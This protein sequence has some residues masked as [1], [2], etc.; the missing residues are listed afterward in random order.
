MKIFHLAGGGDNP[1]TYP[2][3]RSFVLGIEMEL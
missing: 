3:N 2:L 1:R